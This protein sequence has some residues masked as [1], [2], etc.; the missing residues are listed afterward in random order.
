MAS[1]PDFYMHEVKC[2]NCGRDAD[3]YYCVFCDE[4][5]VEIPTLE[6]YDVWEESDGE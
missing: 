6:D 3:D 1:S 4:E 5:V 2:S